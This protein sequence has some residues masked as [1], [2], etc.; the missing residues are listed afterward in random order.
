MVKMVIW[1]S[2][3][4]TPNDFLTDIVKKATTKNKIIRANDRLIQNCDPIFLYPE[5]KSLSLRAHFFA[6]AKYVFG[7]RIDTLYFDLIVIW[8]MSVL[9]YFTLYY[10]L[11]KKTVEL[12]GGRGKA[13]KEA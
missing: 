3:M 1:N 8:M 11:L 6:P 5:N 12:G 9:F 10:D 4:T 2:P 7:R 13:A